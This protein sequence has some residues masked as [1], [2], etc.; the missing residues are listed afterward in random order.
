MR[1]RRRFARSRSFYGGVLAFN[2]RQSTMDCVVRD[3]SSAGAKVTF[4]NAAAVPDDVELS[5]A[6]KEQTF[7]A[8]VVWRR[9]DEAGVAFVD[10]PAAA[11]AGP[12]DWAQRL[13]RCEEERALLRRRLADLSSGW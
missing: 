8:R 6:H 2:A 3:F 11:V 13:R 9:R 5:I 7:R 12:L 1:E 4:A 10:A